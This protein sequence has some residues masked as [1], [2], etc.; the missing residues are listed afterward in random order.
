M[1]FFNQNKKNIMKQN[2]NIL[3]DAL[4]TAKPV[5][6]HMGIFSFFINL[7][8]LVVPIYSLQVL[9]RVLSTGS[10][11]TLFYIFYILSFADYTFMCFD[12]GRGVVG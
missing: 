4:Q 9:D 10:M 3:N 5:F 2:N 6:L 11:E 1:Y 8:M 12:K 7:L